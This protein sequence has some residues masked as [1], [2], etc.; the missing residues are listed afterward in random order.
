MSSL[1]KSLLVASLATSVVGVFVSFTTMPF[2]LVW[3]VAL[4]SGAILG[5]LF[6]ISFVFR[7]H[8][9][10]SVPEETA[11][12]HSAEQPKSPPS[13]KDSIEQGVITPR[14]LSHG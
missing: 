5:G 11:I 3:T 4:P 12:T 10:N 14:L 8:L 2:A 9:F 7:D 6:L 13:E 1:S